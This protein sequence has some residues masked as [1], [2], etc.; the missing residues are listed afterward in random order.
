[1]TIYISAK[2][3]PSIFLLRRG[4]IAGGWIDGGFE[5][6]AEALK[7]ALPGAK[8]MFD[9]ACPDESRALWESVKVFDPAQLPKLRLGI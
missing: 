3:G 1:M 5:M 6:A 9:T 7:A 2:P 8:I 4:T